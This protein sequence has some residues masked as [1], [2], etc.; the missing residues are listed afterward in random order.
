MTRSVLLVRDIRHVAVT[1]AVKQGVHTHTHV[2]TRQRHAQRRKRTSLK[3][4][5]A[6]RTDYSPAACGCTTARSLYSSEATLDKARQLHHRGVGGSPPTWAVYRRHWHHPYRCQAL[7]APLPKPPLRS[8]PA[9]PH[10]GY[11]TPRR[12]WKPLQRLAVSI[13]PLWTTP[14]EVEGYSSLEVRRCGW[15]VPVRGSWCPLVLKPHLLPERGV[16]LRRG[17]HVGIRC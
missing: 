7:Q 3:I 2:C 8:R 4:E 16:D 13:A 6:I 1:A 15:S 12:C 14:V 10:L 9:P 17:A 11:R 5:Q